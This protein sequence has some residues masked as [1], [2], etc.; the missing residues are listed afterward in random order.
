M[1]FFGTKAETAM[2]L[3][4]RWSVSCC[5]LSRSLR[6]DRSSRKILSDSSEAAVQQGVSLPP[7]GE[8]MRLFQGG[9][10]EIGAVWAPCSRTSYFLTN[11]SGW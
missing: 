11:V 7:G 8:G 6:R 5:Y 4:G 3:T 10:S 2:G 1:V 9:Q